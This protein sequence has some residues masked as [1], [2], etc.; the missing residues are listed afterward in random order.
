MLTSLKKKRRL[1]SCGQY[2][3][4][5]KG[6]K[7]RARER[8]NIEK[9]ACLVSEVHLKQYLQEA[10]EILKMAQISK[11]FCFCKLQTRRPTSLQVYT[12]GK[13]I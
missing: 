10:T 1:R 9:Y 11:C 7:G 5:D 2:L 13:N 4:P 3:T 8:E 6:G 12:L